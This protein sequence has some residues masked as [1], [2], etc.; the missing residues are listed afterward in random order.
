LS[1]NNFEKSLKENGQ[2]AQN[3]LDISGIKNLIPPL[4][5]SSLT[6]YF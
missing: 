3:R 4:R 5:N 1:G 6:I 2:M